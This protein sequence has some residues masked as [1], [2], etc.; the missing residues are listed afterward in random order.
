MPLR[1][2]TIH[3][4]RLK[5]AFLLNNLADENDADAS[6]NDDDSVDWNDLVNIRCDS[7]SDDHSE[8]LVGQT[9]IGDP[10][11]D[12]PRVEADE[13]PLLQNEDTDP[14]PLEVSSQQDTP[15]DRRGRL[16]HR[17]RRFVQSLRY[18]AR[19]EN[20]TSFFKLFSYYSKVLSLIFHLF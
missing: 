11:Q 12:M 6:T 13:L 8:D 2:D 9:G 18:V 19:D 1:E 5:P 7:I 15:R 3:V 10:V 16:L 20:S 17:P 4:D 14:A